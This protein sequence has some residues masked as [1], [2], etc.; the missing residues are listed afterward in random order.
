[1]RTELPFKSYWSNSKGIFSE[2]DL[3][4][5]IYHIEG[6][7]LK[8]GRS[9]SLIEISISEKNTK[10]KAHEA[11][12]IFWNVKSAT[13]YPS[14]ENESEGLQVPFDSKEIQL[15]WAAPANHL[16]ID[17]PNGSRLHI[18]KRKK[19][20]SRWN[21]SLCTASAALCFHIFVGLCLL[22]SFSPKA[23]SKSSA[24]EAEILDLRDVQVSLSLRPSPALSGPQ[25]SRNSSRKSQPMTKAERLLAQ[26]D[27]KSL[28]PR[29]AVRSQQSEAPRS[30]FQEVALGNWKRENE[31]QAKPI[32]LEEIRVA[33][34]KKQEDFQSCFER[35]LILDPLLAGQ[36]EIILSFNPLGKI[37]EVR[38][39]QFPSN[40][41]KAKEVFSNCLE[42][43]LHPLQL[44]TSDTGFELRYRLQLGRI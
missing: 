3:P 19:K 22:P 35:S 25:T 20:S 8:P 12:R 6:G 44:Q 31:N 2:R 27:S 29:F 14:D 16:R 26:W 42:A 13:N 17:F 7:L 39:P 1:M 21:T 43:Q 18:E 9:S 38:L 15:T 23:L 36:T 32:A 30:E 33:I 34:Q 40:K 10:V 24:T 41:E 11:C 28:N 4:C 5:G 37:D